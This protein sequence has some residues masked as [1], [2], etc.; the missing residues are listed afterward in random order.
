MSTRIGVTA[1]APRIVDVAP[2]SGADDVTGPTATLGTDPTEALT[3]EA[4]AAERKLADVEERESAAQ[5]RESAAF[6]DEHPAV[7]R[8]SQR[9][10]SADTAAER[11][12]VQRA[13]EELDRRT[14]VVDDYADRIA[15]VAPRF[16]EER[17]EALED[18][19]RASPTGARVLD[20]MEAAGV[21]AEIVS[22]EELQRMIGE[23]GDGL[24]AGAYDSSTKRLVI[25]RDVIDGNA[26]MGVTTLIHEASHAVD[27]SE[28]RMP[29]ADAGNMAIGLLSGAR[30]GIGA[31]FTGDSPI[32]AGR[33][34]FSEGL[35]RLIDDSEARA[36]RIEARAALE[37]GFS[38]SDVHEYN[39]IGLTRDG[40]VRSHEDALREV[41]AQ[42]A[43][44]DG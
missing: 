25:N 27:H 18:M 6:I 39:S 19:A 20:E 28:G 36:Y 22:D 44:L 9:M 40:E 11:S 5:A 35:N 13:Y 42:G 32:T 15:T 29:V 23:T 12:E 24:Y 8:L 26:L 31:V 33:A 4:A 3:G 21:E 43:V 2:D 34:G 14:D 16:D 30:A 17:L 41:H 38:A 7:E 1:T 37:L 10:A